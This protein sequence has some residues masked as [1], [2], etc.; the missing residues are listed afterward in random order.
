MN[1][2]DN[3]EQYKNNENIKTER[4]M[5]YFN[6]LSYYWE[7]ITMN[8]KK[9]NLKNLKEIKEYYRKTFYMIEYNTFMFDDAEQLVKWINEHNNGKL[10]DNIQ[11]KF[12]EWLLT[13]RL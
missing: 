6:F 1:N 12:N 9:Y 5:L 8:S 4:S 3:I 10:P 7:E 13:E 11:Q 2:S